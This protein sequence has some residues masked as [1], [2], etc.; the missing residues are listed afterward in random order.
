VYAIIPRRDLE[1]KLKLPA[2]VANKKYAALFNAT[3]NS[4]LVLLV[5]IVITC[6]IKVTRTTMG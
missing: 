6:D 3:V 1:K 5:V 4:A 2:A